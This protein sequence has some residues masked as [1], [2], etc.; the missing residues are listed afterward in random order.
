M[1]G[2]AVLVFSL[3][4]FLIERQTRHKLI[5]VQGTEPPIPI[6]IPIPDL[7]GMGMGMGMGARPHPHPRF[8][9][10]WTGDRGSA[11]PTPIPDLPELESG[12][13]LPVS[14]IEYCKGVEFR[15]PQ[16]LTLIANC[17]QS[18]LIFEG[19]QC[20]MTPLTTAAAAT[21]VTE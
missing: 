19:R 4:G 7:P 6:P 13:Q 17:Y 18:S 20:P 12:I 2:S 8:A 14:T 11:A 3:G 16:R 15:L 1:Q 9:G 5:H 10:V 21:R